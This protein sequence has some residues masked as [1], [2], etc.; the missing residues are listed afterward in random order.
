MIFLISYFSGIKGSSTSE[1]ADDKY[2]SLQEIYGSDNIKFFTSIKSSFSKNNIIKIP[3][4]SWIDFN[5]EIKNIKLNY[6]LITYKYFIYI[7]SKAYDYFFKFFIK[8]N[9][10]SR[11]SWFLTSSLVILIYFIK[12]K[13]KFVLT[14]GGAAS[15]HLIGLFLKF[16]FNFNLIVEL[17][18]PLVGESIGRNINAQKYFL[19]IEKKIINNSDKIVF[20]SK[21]A[22]LQCLKRYP[23]NKNITYLYPGARKFKDINY[24]YFPSF[25]KLKFIHLG[26]LYGSRNMNLFLKAIDNLIIA[27]K[28]NLE[29][30]EV[31]NCGD[32]YID[33]L[34]EYKTKKY[35]NNISSINR[36]DAL[37]KIKDYNCLLLI[38]HTD[39]RSKIT[40]PFKLYDYLNFS[41]PIFGLINNNEIEEML[42]DDYCADNY[43]IKS[44]ENTI[45]NLKLDIYNKKIINR[46]I[47]FDTKMQLKKIFND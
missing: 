4:L 19:F 12:F 30:I 42:I 45:L 38:Q 2:Y 24:S 13:P 7:F 34:S 47:L 5:D 27:K 43:S 26:T 44:I 6:Y 3:S 31:C 14:T 36:K 35:F 46:K 11:W 40:I 16:F 28:I 21:N 22:Y 10:E 29:E 39:K 32:I 33:E 18:D 23:K 20:V 17:Q 41:I 15:A 8:G 1:W 25:N 37:N 9:S